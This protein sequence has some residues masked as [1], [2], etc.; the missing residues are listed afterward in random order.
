MFNVPKVLVE[1]VHF[2]VETRDLC[3][4][5]RTIFSSAEAFVIRKLVSKV[6]GG[7]IVK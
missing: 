7:S 4:P 3:L 2:L 1:W 6:V 5:C